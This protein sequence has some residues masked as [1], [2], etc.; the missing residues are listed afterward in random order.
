MKAPKYEYDIYLA[1]P[2]AQLSKNPNVL[3]IYVRANGGALYGNKGSLLFLYN[4]TE[5]TL[6]WAENKHPFSILGRMKISETK[7]IESLFHN[8]E[9]KQSNRRY[10]CGYYLIYMSND[11]HEDEL[12]IYPTEKHLYPKFE[13]IL[14]IVDTTL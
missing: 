6:I 8:A 7:Y 11:Y 14:S 4:S 9:R 2:Y 12:V 3:F 5:E 10:D 1:N 13:L